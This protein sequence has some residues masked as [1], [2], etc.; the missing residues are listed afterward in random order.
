MPAPPAIHLPHYDH[1]HDHDHYHHN[2]N[3]YLPRRPSIV[4][5][6]LHTHYF[7]PVPQP[8]PYEPFSFPMIFNDIPEDVPSIGKAFP[9]SS[10][11]SRL[12]C[13]LTDFPDYEKENMSINLDDDQSIAQNSPPTVGKINV[14]DLI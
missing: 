2:H 10:S 12:I 8:P 3:P 13:S 11:S 4:P 1:D 14:F 9:N 7:N 6:G 5:S